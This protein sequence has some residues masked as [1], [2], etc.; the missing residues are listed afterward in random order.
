MSSRHTRGVEAAPS[1]GL[2]HRTRPKACAARRLERCRLFQLTCRA[3]L[4]RTR[5]ALE[6]TRSGRTR[7]RQVAPDA[8]RGTTRMSGGLEV[9][10]SWCV[11]RRPIVGVQLPSPRWRGCHLHGHGHDGR[12]DEQPG[13]KAR[14]GEPQINP[15]S[16]GAIHLYL[17]VCS[18]VFQKS[19]FSIRDSANQDHSRSPLPR[20]VRWEHRPRLRG[21]GVGMHGGQVVNVRAKSRAR[22]GFGSSPDVS[23]F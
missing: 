3:A 9:C 12:R 20:M 8:F 2:K 5:S 11:L 19:A 22:G 16:P 21:I 4:E 18:T 6:R 15:D 23:R 10:G 13:R 7:E 1:G 14:G 17:M